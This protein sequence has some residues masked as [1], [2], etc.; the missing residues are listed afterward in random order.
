MV[1]FLI[2]VVIVVVVIKFLVDLSKDNE[3][4]YLSESLNKKF[5]VIVRLLND[6]AFA[7][8][9]TITVVDKREFILYE[10]NSN[11]IIRFFYSTGNLTLE[12][13]FKYFQKEVISRKIY[14]DVRNI[15]I[16]EQDKIANDFIRE[17]SLI[18]EKHKA[19]VTKDIFNT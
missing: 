18:F 12:W 17:S 13:K 7:G 15:S 3:D 2:I 5:T 14:Y 16:F 10:H 9:G 8:R 11:Q 6:V 19:E 4:I 1:W